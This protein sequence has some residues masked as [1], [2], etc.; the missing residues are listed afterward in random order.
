MKLILSLFEAIDI[1]VIM[2]TILLKMMCLSAVYLFTFESVV[3][4]QMSTLSIPK[5]VIKWVLLYV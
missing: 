5:I 2:A 4:R 3:L 1:L